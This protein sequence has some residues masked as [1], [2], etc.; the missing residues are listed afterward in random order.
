MGPAVLAGWDGLRA[1]SGPGSQEREREREREREADD[2]GRMGRGGGLDRAG[3][4]RLGEELVQA[5][6]AR[7]PAVDKAGLVQFTAALIPGEALIP[8]GGQR[9]RQTD[10]D[11]DR[12]KQ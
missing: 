1:G 12:D 7:D 3:G 2:A 6:A 5:A 9:E 4:A 10:R 8:G 11:R